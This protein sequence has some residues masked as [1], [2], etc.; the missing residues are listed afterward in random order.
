MGKKTDNPR[1]FSSNPSKG[2]CEKFFLLYSLFWISWA[3]GIVVP[4][5]L[6]EKCGKLEYMLICLAASLPCALFPLCFVGKADAALPVLE[7]YWVK[8]NVW[9]AVFSF[10]GNYFWT[11]YFY[12][13]LGAS[14]TFPSWRLNEVPICLYFMTHAYFCFYH[15]LSNVLLRRVRFAVSDKPAA[16]RW[17]ASAALVFALAYATA[18]GETLTISAFPYYS[19]KDKDKM[20]SVGSLFYAIYFFVSFPMF[21]RMDEPPSRK[22]TVPEAA[23]D[24]LAAGMLVTILL[25]LWRISFGGIVDSPLAGPPSWMA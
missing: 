19:F 2:W 4:F 1:W 3:L 12:R 23:L 18:Y 14:Y 6:Y 17:A 5:G 20:Y 15:S 13:L 8:A 25:D 10:I 9:V 11:H 24:S 22:W 7:R 16:V 21:F